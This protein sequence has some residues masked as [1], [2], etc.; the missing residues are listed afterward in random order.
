MAGDT[1]VI[2]HFKDIERSDELHEALEKRCQQL[3]TEFPETDRYEL[4]LE[5]DANDHRAHIHVSGK[6]TSVASHA[7]AAEPR[8]A[9]EAALDRI[10]RELR[11]DHDKRI[12]TP[13]REA[14]R[15]KA[16]H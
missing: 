7:S 8:Q 16:R 15:T 9:A 1:T 10:E 4:T 2:V 14:R 13:R 6:H 3:A 12:F 5:P 11:K